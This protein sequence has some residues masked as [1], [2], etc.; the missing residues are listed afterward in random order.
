MSMADPIA[1]MFT[2]IRN[3]Q[4]SRKVKVQLPASKLK[5]AIAEVLKNEGYI[6]GCSVDEE[7]ARK[8]TLV[9]ELKY[10]QG[11]AVIETIQRVSRPSRRVYRG[12]EEIPVVRGGLGITIVSTSKG[13]MTGKAARATGQG[14]EIVAFVA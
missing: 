2:S 5:L 11:K 13:I 10:F 1:D 6:K 4:S 12:K 7:I 3:A 8:P 14:G 9:I